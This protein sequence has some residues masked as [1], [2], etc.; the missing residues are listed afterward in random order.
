MMN[1]ME[2]NDRFEKV[3]LYGPVEQMQ[4]ASIM[5]EAMPRSSS[6]MVCTYID[7]VFYS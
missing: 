6:G 1:L 5:V 2:Y 3:R 4:G 7:S